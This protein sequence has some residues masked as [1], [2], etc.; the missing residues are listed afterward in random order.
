MEADARTDLEGRQVSRFRPL[1]LEQAQQMFLLGIALYTPAKNHGLGRAGASWM[2]RNR[3]MIGY[4]PAC[5]YPNFYAVLE[6]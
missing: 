1:T 5:P 4:M 6:E 2:P 3:N